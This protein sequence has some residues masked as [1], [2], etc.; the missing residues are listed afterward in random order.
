[1]VVNL[2]PAQ[3]GWIRTQVE[4]GKFASIEDAVR[5]LIDERIAAYENGVG[6]DLEW[7]KPYIAEGLAAIERGDVVT[8]EEHKSRNAARVADLMRR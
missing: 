1:M 6:D 7:T 4:T 8:L 5:Q 2:T 3:E